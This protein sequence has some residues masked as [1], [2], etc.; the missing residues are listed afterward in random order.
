MIITKSKRLFENAQEKIPGAVNSPVRAWHAVTGMPRFI[1]R[2]KGAHIFDVDGNRYVDY[3]GSWGPLI[4]GHAHPSIT[5]AVIAATKNGTSFG[6]PH[7]AEVELAEL[8]CKTVPSVQK[9]R[10]V[11]SGTEATA[12]AIRL[13]RGATSRDCI[14]KFEGCYH[15]A[16]DSFLVK[17]GSGV[18]TLG[19]PDSPGVPA[20]LAALTLTAPFND[21][22]AAEA[23]FK[24]RGP[25]IAAVIVEPVVGN[26]GVLV[27]REG[28]LKGLQELASRHGALLIFDEVMTGFRVARGGAQA[29]YGVRPDLTTLG[30]VIGG[31]LPV[32]AYGGRRELMAKIAPEGPVYQAGTLSGNPLAVAAGI[33][34]LRE[35]AKPGAY[36]RL[37]ATSRALTDGVQQAARQAGV[38]LTLNRVGSMWTAFF[39]PDPVFDYR[40]ARQA[41][42]Q[43]F[44]RFFHALL[45]LGVYLPPSQFEAAFVSLAHGDDEVRRTLEAVREALGKV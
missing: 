45:D 42:T 6:A 22:E 30:K 34:T 4:L 15:G 44:G 38:P 1:E 23:V 12:A 8:I 2:G 29:L 14:L 28:Y 3:V 16:A 40:S 24:K 27:P 10:L 33:A 25:E 26:M 39:T 43:R 32:G 9:V 31:G 20:A 5:D 37:E 21:L 41:D 13:A 36:E 7:A 19:L 35:L 17:A 18:E 11:S